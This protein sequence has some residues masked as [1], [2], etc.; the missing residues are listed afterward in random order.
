M[1]CGAHIGGYDF[2][3]DLRDDGIT[4]GAQLTH[5]GGNPM[6]QQT[7]AGFKAPGF[8]VCSGEPL[9]S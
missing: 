3:S 8:P 6:S 9:G 7:N 1:S 5:S 2:R 4:E